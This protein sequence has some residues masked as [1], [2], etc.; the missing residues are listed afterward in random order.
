MSISSNVAYFNGQRVEDFDL[1]KGIQDPS[2]AYRFRTDYDGKPNAVV[3][4]IQVFLKD[5]KIEHV[6]NLVIGMWGVEHDESPNEIIQILVQSKDKLKNLKGI[7]FGDITYEEN[8]ISW[9]ENTNHA[10]VLDAFPNLEIYQVRGGNGLSFG[11]LEHA[12]LQK[13]VVQT[14]GISKKVLKEV[15]EADLPALEHLEL[16]LGARDYGFDSS[17]E[18]VM[19]TYRGTA[20]KTSHLPKLTYLGLRNSEIADEIAKNLQGDSIL[21]K[22]EVLDLSMGMIA[23]E[24]AKA[25]FDNPA[26]KNLRKLDLHHNFISDDWAEKLADM[27]LKVDLSERDTEEEED[28]R[29]VEVGE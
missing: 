25:L 9:I 29:Y 11:K 28:Y 14:G 7:F 3:N 15:A 2:I 16:W 22:I 18:E 1:E 24:G 26:I 21:D 17:V 23:D 8:E 4:A 10:P 5:E 12:N 19:A 20:G 13:L 6:Q 27:G